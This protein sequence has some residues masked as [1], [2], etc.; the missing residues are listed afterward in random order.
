MYENPHVDLVLSLI[1]DDLAYAI[2]ATAEQD[3]KL[4]LGDIPLAKPERVA[5]VHRDSIWTGRPLLQPFAV[6]VHLPSMGGRAVLIDEAGEA[7]TQWEAVRSERRAL[8]H[9]PHSAPRIPGAAAVFTLLIPGWNRV[10][11]LRN[12]LVTVAD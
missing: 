6:F 10:V 4:E 3:P 5:E 9:V 1:D 2:I 8:G 7:A 12:R 11:A